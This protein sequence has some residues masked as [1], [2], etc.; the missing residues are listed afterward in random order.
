MKLDNGYL[1]VKKQAGFKMD[2]YYIWCSSVLYE[3]GMFYM[4]AARWP[5]DT[6][7][8]DGYMTNSEIV[9]AETDDLDKPFQFKKVVISKRSGNYWD[10]TMAHNPF[11]TKID[12]TYILYYIGSSDGSYKNRAIGYACAK[13][14]DGEWIRNDKPIDLP[15]DANNPSVLTDD[16]GSVLLYFRDGSLKVSV[17]RAKSYNGN[18][19][20]EN[21]NLFPEGMIE[22]MFVFRNNGRYEMFAEDAGGVYTGI[23]KAGV[24][25]VSDNGIDWKLHKK[26]LAYD[27]DV[28]YTDGT[29][30]SLQRRERPQILNTGD[31]IY[32]LN[33]VKADGPDRLTGGHTWNMVQQFCTD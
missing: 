25:F 21:D 4:F 13:S 15:P 17:A 10:S 29:S 2:G 18:Y 28:E 30:I 14:L 27:F 5:E 11:I 23:T 12:D 9:L 22:D 6:S 24:Y 20:V 32:L 8:P 26:P 33:A 7:F 3:N 31:K 16:D 19:I 1:P